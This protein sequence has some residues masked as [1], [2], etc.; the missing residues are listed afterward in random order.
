[1]RELSHTSKRKDKMFI[2]E[3]TITNKILQNIAKIEHTKAIT[4]MCVILDSLRKRQQ[5]EATIDFIRKNLLLEGIKTSEEEIKK[6]IDKITPFPAGIIHGI[7]KGLEITQYP[8]ISLEVNEKDL[9]ELYMATKDTTKPLQVFRD[10]KYHNSD[11]ESAPEEILSNITEFLDWVNSLDGRETH[12]VVKAGIIKGRLML[13]KPF[14]TNN[15]VVSN[16]FA[17]KYLREEKYNLNDYCH[18]EMAYVED[19]L[20][21]KDALESITKEGDMTTWINFYTEA[22]AFMAEKKREEILLLSKD[23]KILQASGSAEL[24][25][26][27]EIIVA[28]LQDYGKIQNKDFEIILPNVSEDSVL[29]DLKVLMDKGIV[30]KKGKTKS[31][32]YELV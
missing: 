27:Q 15:E 23:T 26:R 18:L 24:T 16:L 1:M 14:V 21:Y 10:R 4:E 5:K 17:Y 30:V 2:P 29:R 3:Y 32:R 20:G 13:I 11:A 31:S 19:L 25:E 8:T 12:P 7:K 28:Y 22:M 6:Y 9:T